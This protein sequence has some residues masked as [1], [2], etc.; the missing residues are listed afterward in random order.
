M[1]TNQGP[2][3]T[4]T[5][6]GSVEEATPVV[7]SIGR[8]IN[9]GP[10]NSFVI[11]DPFSAVIA[12]GVGELVSLEQDVQIIG[13][14]EL[15]SIE[16]AVEL[17]TTGS[18][19]LVSIEQGVQATASGELVSV[20]QRVRDQS[21]GTRLS[22]AGW[23]C[24]VLVGG[25]N[26]S[27]TLHGRMDIIKQENSSTLATFTLIPA[28][29]VQDLADYEGK[30]VTI[31]LITDMGAKRVFTGIVDIP[32]IDLIMQTITFRCTNRRSE[33]VNDYLST[34]IKGIGYYSTDLFKT[35]AD[36]AEELEQRLSTVFQ[37]LDYDGNNVGQLVGK[38]PRATADFTFA[39]SG[40]FRRTP[41]VELTPRARILNTVNLDLT[42]RYQ[43][44]HHL[45]R[46]YSWT[47][48]TTPTEFCNIA[49]KGYTLTRKDMIEQAAKSA[50]WPL[51]AAMSFTG[52]PESGWYRCGDLSIAYSNITTN[53]QS[54]AKRDSDGNTITDS[55]GNVIYESVVQSQTNLQDIFAGSASWTA[56]SRLSQTMEENYTVSI[57]SPQSITR[58]GVI[59]KNESVGIEAEYDTSDWEDYDQFNTPPGS[60]SGNYH[61]NKDN[62]VNNLNEMYRA[63]V[64]RAQTQIRESH[65]QNKVTLEVPLKPE[66]ELVHTVETTGDIVESKGKCTRIQHVLD[67]GSTDAYT[68]IETSLSTSTGSSSTT[69]VSNADRPSDTVVYDTQPI[70]LRSKYGVAPT[71]NDTGFIGNAIVLRR[72]TN[73]TVQ[74]RVDTPTVG[75][76][77]RDNKQ[78]PSTTAVTTE[79]PNDT[80]TVTFND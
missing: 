71:A 52:I 69:P 31:D 13:L 35:A 48:D 9:R 12:S 56:T 8:G 60:S 39:D 77:I 53:S 18:G 65:R 28:I 80:L 79:I 41:K 29:G 23:D 4:F 47:G 27:D 10:V 66:V 3:N 24:I 7:P 19:V 34:I 78:V 76:S 74:F 16:Q 17:L 32:D 33:L 44:L 75:G 67:F 61:I 63:A 62:N 57:T 5:V 6:N 72:M 46:T 64:A 43:R 73:Y 26:V 59:D 40:I 1:P 38:D 21:I 36:P 42:Y 11:N 15:V 14:G 51:K 58:Y 20:I 49:V 2:I 68:V 30:P 25:V 22:R 45:E 50:G 55:S 37:S 70:F 54:V